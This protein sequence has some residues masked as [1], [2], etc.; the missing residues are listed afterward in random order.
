MTAL[1]AS[2][3]LKLKAYMDV[4]VCLNTSPATF[5]FIEEEDIGIILCHGVNTPNNTVNFLHVPSE[6]EVTHRQHI[7]KDV[8][9]QINAISKPKLVTLARSVRDGFTPRNLSG[10]ME[11]NILQALAPTNMDSMYNVIYDK[12]LL[13]GIAGWSSRYKPDLDS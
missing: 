7:L 13:G 8:L 11:R 5:G 3:Y 12:N 1:Y 2:T 9:H 6:R 4:G 10:V